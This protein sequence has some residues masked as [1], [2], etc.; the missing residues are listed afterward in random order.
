MAA[1]GREHM[2]LALEGRFEDYNGWQE[3]VTHEA[4]GRILKL[5]SPINMVSHE[6]VPLGFGGRD[7][8]TNEPRSKAVKK[9]AR[10]GH[11]CAS[12]FREFTWDARLLVFEDDMD[13]AN[14]LKST[15]STVPCNYVDVL[16]RGSDALEKN[17]ASSGQ[18]FF[19]FFN[20]FFFFFVEK[21][22]KKRKKNKKKIVI[23]HY[24]AVYRPL[25][26]WPHPADQHAHQSYPVI[27]LTQKDER[28][29]KLRPMI[30]RRMITSPSL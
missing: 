26:G 22:K 25:R 2:A 15:F 24:V 14:M 23:G 29:D 12:A 6:W 19:M 1:T 16:W 5:R 21:K 18:H 28:S 9:N 3:N 13:I 11:S 10:M 7:V 20:F 4:C 17:K 27:F 8:Q 30:G